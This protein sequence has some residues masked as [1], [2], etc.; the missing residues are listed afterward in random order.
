MIRDFGC[1]A[2]LVEQLTLNQPVRGSSPRAPTN[3]FNDLIKLRRVRQLAVSALC[4]QLATNICKLCIRPCAAQLSE[5]S[6]IKLIR[7][8]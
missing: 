4:Q 7:A 2:Q 6:V 3:N 1:V 5:Q 8:T